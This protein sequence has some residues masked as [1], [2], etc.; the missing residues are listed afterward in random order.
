MPWPFRQATQ[1]THPAAHRLSPFSQYPTLDLTDTARILLV[2]V[3]DRRVAP[4]VIRR[5]PTR[6][7]DIHMPSPES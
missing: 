1:K 3:P 4:T 6:D 7:T 2:T 5:I